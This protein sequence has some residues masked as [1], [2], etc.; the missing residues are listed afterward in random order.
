MLM[1]VDQAI[2]IIK[3]QDISTEAAILDDIWL[4]LEKKILSNPIPEEHRKIL[5]QRLDK[6]E[7]GKATFTDW[8]T[9]KA[10]LLNAKAH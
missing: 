5:D 6:I 4:D 9:L 7:S 1:G 8:E 2:A 3:S 10:K